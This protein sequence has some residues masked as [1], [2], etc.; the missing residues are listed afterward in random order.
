LVV[1]PLP[2][3]CKKLNCSIDRSYWSST[4]SLGFLGGGDDRKRRVAFHASGLIFALSYM[5]WYGKEAPKD[6]PFG[7]S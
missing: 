3:F 5:P 7:V 6:V 4:I 1:S 2:F